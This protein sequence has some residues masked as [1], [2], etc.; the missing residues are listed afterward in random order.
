MMRRMNGDTLGRPAVAEA[1]A[2]DEFQGR[3]IVVDLATV[4]G[5]T[6]EFEGR[7]WL[8]S[9]LRES[10]SVGWD[11]EWV[12]DRTKDMDNPV[13]LMQFADESTVLLVRTHITNWLPLIISKVL[14][15]ETCHKISVGW[16][17][18]DKRKMKQTFNLEPLGVKDLARLAERKGL[19]G[20]G[21]KALSDHFGYNM[22]KDSRTARS[23][24]AAR[25]LSKEQIQYAA[26]DAYFTYLL[27]EKLEALPNV[28]VE[29][30][31]DA[32]P[33]AQGLLQLQPG[34]EEQGIE[35][36]GDGLHCSLCAQGP[37]VVPEVVEKHIGGQKHQK[38]LSLRQ[39]RIHGVLTPIPLSEMYQEQG[40]LSGDIINGLKIGEMKCTI[41]D[42]GPFLN[43]KSVDDHIQSA[44]HKKKMAPLPDA[45]PA[46]QKEGGTSLTSAAAEAFDAIM[47]NMPD[48]VDRKDPTTLRCTLCGVEQRAVEPMY[49]HLNG[50]RHAKS[51]RTNGLEEIVFIKEKQR[52]EHMISGK[53]VVRTGHKKP[54]SG[55]A[56]TSSS[57]APKDL[58]AKAPSP[59]VEAQRG[60]ETQKPEKVNKV[61]GA[62]KPQG[63]GEKEVQEDPKQSGWCSQEWNDRVWSEKVD[64]WQQPSNWQ[65]S[66]SAWTNGDAATTESPALEVPAAATCRQQGTVEAGTSPSASST[67]PENPSDNDLPSGWEVYKDPNTEQIYYWCEATQEVSHTRP[68]QP[69]PAVVYSSAAPSSVAA[70]R[71]L[72]PD[73]HPQGG[74]LEPGWCAFTDPKTGR[75]YYQ[76]Y[77]TKGPS[78]WTPPPQYVSKGWTRHLDKEGHPYWACKQDPS[79]NFY[80][81]DPAWIRRPEDGLGAFYWVCEERGERFYEA[82]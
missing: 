39:G 22:R 18:P 49:L 31:P 40:I 16:D 4:N 51:C 19:A 56:G 64:Q 8:E 34:W 14:M 29:E 67:M 61:T 43:L 54:R 33:M 68:T 21:L 53:A 6:E 45:E 70:E 17:G 10:R 41:C 5:Q 23:D 1:R 58:D 13:A 35:R 81:S 20:R 52:V 25:E 48:Y 11:I 63:Q 46:N 62:M 30:N 77:E 75:T 82:G 76:D 24:W 27:Y 72:Q 3:I 57:R 37:M 79:L 9:R 73:K 59:A 36:K 69:A 80:E 71:P 26:E 2:Y 47:W 55:E 78:T 65:D 74:F 60:A 28:T 32:A 7:H 66:S 12:P 38:R 50:D 44:K 42:A 15:S